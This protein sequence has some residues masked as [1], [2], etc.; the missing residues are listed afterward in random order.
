MVPI[1][2]IILF[3]LMHGFQK[4]IYNQVFSQIKFAITVGC[5]IIS[6]I[7]SDVRLTGTYIAFIFLFRMFRVGF[8]YRF[9]L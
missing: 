8:S 3:L 7:Q 4:N 1:K 6:L 9:T 2:E 5:M